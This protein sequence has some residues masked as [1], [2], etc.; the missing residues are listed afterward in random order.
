MSGR[1]RFIERYPALEAGEPGSCLQIVR[2]VV[3]G[4][5]KGEIKAV[6]DETWS[7]R[8]PAVVDSEDALVV[9]SAALQKKADKGYPGYVT[10]GFE[11]SVRDGG[12]WKTV[13]VP[14]RDI[15][16]EGWLRRGKGL[17]DG[18]GELVMVL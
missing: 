10:I 7:S 4:K 5:K 9:V 14:P 17:F 6:W 13:L 15:R 11:A 3:E 8:R 12:K 16:W 2:D 18:S 1:S